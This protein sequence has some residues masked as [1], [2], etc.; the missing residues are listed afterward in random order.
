[1][2][3]NQGET[4][5]FKQGDKVRY[6]SG[7]NAPEWYGWEGV[8]DWSNS[9]TTHAKTTNSVKYS[10]VG[11]GANLTTY[12]LELITEEEKVEQTTHDFKAGDRVEFVENYSDTCKTGTQVTLT[13]VPP[14]NKINGFLYYR[15]ADG[16]TGFCY[17]KRVKKVGFTFAD[18]QVGDKIRRTLTRETGTTEVREGTVVELKRGFATDAI[19]TGQPGS[20]YILAYDSDGDPAKPQVV[21]ELLDRPK[22]KHWTEAKPVGSVGVYVEGTFTKT[23]TK[24]GVNEWTVLYAVDGYTY[25]DN[26]SGLFARFGT[27]DDSK[28]TWIK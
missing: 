10:K 7:T 8:V 3:H 4:L 6:K 16:S 18:I 14:Q 17:P 21:L 22:P 15:E 13:S 26:N 11:D 27:L 19:S 20:S 28:V 12:N 1:M 25:K 24:S 9:G 2:G 23:Y 5:T